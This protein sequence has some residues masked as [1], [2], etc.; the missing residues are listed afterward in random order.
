MN[1]RFKDHPSIVVH[2]RTVTDEG[3]LPHRFAVR[4]DASAY[5]SCEE[6]LDIVPEDGARGDLTFVHRDFYSGEYF[7]LDDYPT[8]SA[9]FEAARNHFEKRRSLV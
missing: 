1:V 6:I 8:E 4:K 5:V 3:T 9:A 7:R 2:S